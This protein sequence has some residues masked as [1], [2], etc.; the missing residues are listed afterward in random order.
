MRTL[1]YIVSGLL[2]VVAVAFAALSTSDTDKRTMI[3][4]YSLDSSSVVDG[5]DGLR[6]HYTDQGCRTCPALVLVHGSNASLHTFIPIIELLED[7]FRII[8]Y[9]QPGHGLTGPHPRDDYSAAGYAAALDVVLE[10]LGVKEFA[11]AGN[12]MGGWVSWRYALENPNRLTALILIDA[13]GAPPPA[14]AEQRRL[15]LGARIMRHPVGRWLARYITPRSIIKQSLLDTVAD[16]SLVTDKLI[17]RYWELLRFPGN[18]RA[19]G[20]RA[21]TDREDHKA[22]RLSEISAPTLIIWGAEDRVTPPYDADTFDAIIPNSQKVVFP[23]VGHVPMEEAPK[24]TADTINVFLS[25]K[26]L[27]SSSGEF[28]PSSETE[29]D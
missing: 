12:S 22:D 13:S 16:E 5:P 23:G 9:D 19:A 11:L 25:T 15:Y 6:V 24:Q 2:I 8:A 27:K 3:A 14:E 29:E 7:R 18:R 17:D 1:A 20:I 21:V 4:K 28:S 26:M 10:H